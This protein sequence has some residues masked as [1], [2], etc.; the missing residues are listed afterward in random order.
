MSWGRLYQ[1]QSY[2]D[3]EH[4]INITMHGFGGV[5]FMNGFIIIVMVFLSLWIWKN[6]GKLLGS[7]FK[8]I[9]KLISCC[10]KF[11]LSVPS[12]LWR[13]ERH[14][15]TNKDYLTICVPNISKYRSPI[16]YIKPSVI[17][18]S[19]GKPPKPSAVSSPQ[20]PFFTLAPHTYTLY[21]LIIVIKLDNIDRHP[22]LSDSVW[23][24][25]GGRR[26]RGEEVVPSVDRVLRSCLVFGA[27]F[28]GRVSPVA[29]VHSHRVCNYLVS[30]GK[31]VLGRLYP[32]PLLKRQHYGCLIGIG[33]V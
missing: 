28:N 14:I 29:A 13:K 15:T 31:Q 18:I 6:M 20:F 4:C 9:D 24:A 11:N 30:V 17:S 10:L 12:T 7:F 25:D 32:L 5:E 27:E 33:S 1:Y 2:V 3:Y 16:E 19:D 8:L 26:L 22:L 23:Q 21:Y